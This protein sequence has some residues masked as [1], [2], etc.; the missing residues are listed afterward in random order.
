MGSLSPR[1]VRVGDILLVQSWSV[2]AC[3][4]ACSSLSFRYVCS[5]GCVCVCVCVVYVRVYVCVCLCVYAM[6]AREVYTAKYVYKSRQ[7]KLRD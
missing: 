6:L 4:C 5:C 7:P 1:T 3:V 2:S